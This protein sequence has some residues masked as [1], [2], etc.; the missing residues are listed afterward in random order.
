MNAIACEASK[1]DT[2]ALNAIAGNVNINRLDEK[3]V[4]A[5]AGRAS[6]LEYSVLS[7]LSKEAHRLNDDALNA[8]AGHASELDKNQLYILSKEARRLND[9]ALNAIAYKASITGISLFNHIACKA[10]RISGDVLSAIARKNN[11][12]QLNDEAINA[13]ACEASRLDCDALNVI[14][15]YACQQKNPDALTA[16]ACQAGR[17]DS[18]SLNVI[19]GY[20]CQ[21]NNFDALNA[22]ACEASK[23]DS[24]VLNTIAKNTSELTSPAAL[25]AIEKES[26]RLNPDVSMHLM[27]CILDKVRR[28]KVVKTNIDAITED[29]VEGIV[30]E[31]IPLFQRLSS[32]PEADAKRLDEHSYLTDAKNDF[33][34][35]VLF[36]LFNPDGM[37]EQQQNIIDDCLDNI[38]M[39]QDDVVLECIGRIMTAYPGR[40]VLEH[41]LVEKILS[42]TNPESEDVNRF[43]SGALRVNTYIKNQKVYSHAEIQDKV[44][45]LSHAEIQHKL[46]QFRKYPLQRLFSY[47]RL[48]GKLHQDWLF[49]NKKYSPELQNAF[50]TQFGL[51]IK[52]SIVTPPAEKN[53]TEVSLEMTTTDPELVDQS[54]VEEGNSIFPANLS[55]S[56]ISMEKIPKT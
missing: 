45:Q 15:R 38:S 1:L 50:D 55:V 12:Y 46:S 42:K 48:M 49:E 25:N 20:A 2:N 22:I 32:L 4:N 7:T 44:S 33:Y 28:Y 26:R 34:S 51:I 8:I 13:I 43:F 47:S 11:F 5:I 10:H 17:L 36:L 54:D 53:K 52:P 3:A 30:E 23:L 41:P 14:A 31:F 18:R 27:K 35:L 29:D 40:T 56:N 6:E 9:H 19:V 24:N 21:Q 37:D 16:I 39:I